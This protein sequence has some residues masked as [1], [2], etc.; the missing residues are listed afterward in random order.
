MSTY[1]GSLDALAKYRIA[2]L[3]LEAQNDRLADA[4]LRTPSRPLRIRLAEQ[5]R[6][7]AEW[8]E[9]RPQLARA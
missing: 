3:Q 1:P 2:E 4:V 8:I 7:V 9:G 5:L 6:S